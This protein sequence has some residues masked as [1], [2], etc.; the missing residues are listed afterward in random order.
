MKLFHKKKKTKK[1]KF[2]NL[3]IDK[4]HVLFFST[5]R[6][7]NSLVDRYDIIITLIDIV[8]DYQNP[9]FDDAV[10]AVV[11]LFHIFDL[12]KKP[13]YNQCYERNCHKNITTR[14][15]TVT[16][17]LDDGTLIKSNKS[18]LS[19]HS[20]MFRGMFRAGGFKESYENTVRLHNVSSECFKCILL[21]LDAPIL[22][23]CMFPT[24]INLFLELLVIT[25]MFMFDL[26]FENSC[27]LS[28]KYIPME[29]YF[30]VYEAINK[31][32]E[33]Y[34]SNIVDFDDI[35]YL[36]SSN[37]CFPDRVKTIK[38]FIEN[39]SRLGEYFTLILKIVLKEKFSFLYV[40]GE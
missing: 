4:L 36:F 32:H 37:S 22:C 38:Y 5:P 24:D 13:E 18:L 27:K 12:D 14:E 20:S 21:L 40:R 11:N 25:D 3:I 35:R 19:I 26:L 1:L 39:Y 6:I 7:L 33:L 10:G 30:K 29:G 31:I 2:I 23:E 28:V 17:I 16:F 9:L 8:K 15:T 34:S